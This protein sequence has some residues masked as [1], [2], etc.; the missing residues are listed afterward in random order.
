MNFSRIVNAIDTVFRWSMD[1]PLQEIKDT[2]AS[3]SS[4][5]GSNSSS[6]RSKL[7]GVSEICKGT[8]L[9]GPGDGGVHAVGILENSLKLDHEIIAIW[10]DWTHASK[11]SSRAQTIKQDVLLMGL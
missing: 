9:V 10:L 8:G 6:G 3:R 2:T 5:K 11:L 4:V 7:E 1:V